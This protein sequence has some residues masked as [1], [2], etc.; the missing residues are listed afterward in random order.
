VVIDHWT[1]GAVVPFGILERPA[2]R[3]GLRIISYSRP[4]C[5]LSTP[6]PESGTAAVVADAAT[7]TAAILDHLGL[8]EFV[9]IGWSGGGPSPLACA[10]LMPERCRGVASLASLGP[11]DAE[12]LDPFAGMTGGERRRVRRRR[13]GEEALKAKLEQFVAPML[14][15][16]DDRLLEALRGMFGP[17]LTG[18]LGDHAVACMRHSIHQG[19]VGWRDDTLAQVRPWGF[20]LDQIRVPVSIWH[21]A[22]DGNVGTEHAVW[23]SEHIP[24]TRLRIAE[25]EG[26]VSLILRIARSSTTCSSEQ[27]SDL[28]FSRPAR[29]GRAASAPDGSSGGVFRRSCFSSTPLVPVHH[30]RQHRLDGRHR[31]PE[32]A[33]EDHRGSLVGRVP[34]RHTTEGDPLGCV[35]SAATAAGGRMDP[36]VEKL[37]DSDNPSIA[38]RVH[39]RLDGQGEDEENQRRRRQRVAETSNVRRLLSR[40]GPDGTIRLGNEYHCYRKFQGAHWTMAALAELGYPHGDVSLLPVVDQVHEWLSSPKHL[41]PPSTQVILGQEDRVRR[42][43]SQEGLAIWYLHELGLVDERVDVLVSRLVDDQWPDGGWNCDKAPAARTSSVQETLLPLRGLARHIRSGQE[44][45][46]VRDAVDRAAQ[47]LLDRRL[48]WR[49]H[50]GAPIRPAWGRDPMRIQW[51]IRFYD[52][53]SALTVMA[54]ID[55]VDSPG[56]ADALGI[57]AAKRLKTGGYPAEVRTAETVDTVTSG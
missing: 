15:L 49:R 42:C 48:L 4:G 20:N 29:A 13:Q 56:C 50:D 17:A 54:E 28:M 25:G 31:L 52:I 2:T 44:G 39:R 37:R 24:A 3:R 40:P 36:Y 45:P 55:R 47:F 16:T 1:P 34:L 11:H 8:G 19:V 26:R 21:G 10:A 38:H 6:R 23:L 57:L 22:E 7:D 33:V 53:L 32:L 35:G 30:R 9:T 14:G 43:A 46:A 27:N 51:P 12:G 5:G 41:S 18:E